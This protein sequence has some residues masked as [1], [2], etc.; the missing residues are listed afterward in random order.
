MVDVVEI[1]ETTVL[2]TAVFIILYYV[3]IAGRL[4][5]LD[6]IMDFIFDSVI[7]F[8]LVV[9]VLRLVLKGLF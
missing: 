4:R 7:K 6:E 8:Y 9:L 5:T 1:N 3:V 2:I